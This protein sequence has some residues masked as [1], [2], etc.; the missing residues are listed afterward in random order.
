VGIHQFSS[1]LYTP[2]IEVP[3]PPQ[4]E[5]SALTCRACYGVSLLRDCSGN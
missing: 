5:E 1:M 4:V 3:S 2:L